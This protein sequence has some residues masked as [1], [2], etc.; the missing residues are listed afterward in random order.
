LVRPI[1]RFLTTI[2][3][4]AW[5]CL[6]SAGHGQPLFSRLNLD[7]LQLVSLGAGYG[8]ILPSQVEPTSV[9]S[10]QA[11]YGEIARS[12]R[13]VFGVSY[14]DSRYRDLVVQTFVDSLNHNLSN[15]SGPQIQSSRVNLYDVTFST[16]ARYTPT[17][18]GELKPYLGF[19][20]AAHVIDAEGKLI[21]GTFVER[22]LDNIAAGAFLTAGVALRIVNHFGVEGGVRAD[23]LSG[24]R[25]TQLR[26]G[27]SYYF[28][29]LRIPQPSTDTTSRQ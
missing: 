15:P 11:D 27:A 8:R 2:V 29:H 10:L 18:S 3:I 4:A 20:L 7:K 14:W 17:Y 21:N 1:K 6:P 16:E 23:L 9:F 25:S 22:S 13:V 28:G 26:A 19:G 24:F 5:V 12:W